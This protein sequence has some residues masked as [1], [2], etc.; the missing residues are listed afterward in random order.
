MYRPPTFITL[1]YIFYKKKEYLSRKN[2]RI[3]APKIKREQAGRKK[4]KRNI[5]LPKERK[6]K[7][8]F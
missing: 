5:V 6:R 3:A 2:E 1:R 7:K 8:N 4:K